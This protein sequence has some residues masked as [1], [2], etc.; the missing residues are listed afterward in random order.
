MDLSRN[1]QCRK[2]QKNFKGD[3]GSLDLSY[4]LDIGR[5]YTHRQRA[6]RE[7]A[8]V[9]QLRNFSCRNLP[10]KWKN[11]QFCYSALIK[12]RWNAFRQL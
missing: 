10:P 12:Q 9:G 7:G 2:L 4:E 5:D 11:K 3:K 6:V 8:A 1:E